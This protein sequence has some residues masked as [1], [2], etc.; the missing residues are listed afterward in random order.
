MAKTS[1]VASLYKSKI[2]NPKSKIELAAISFPP[3]RNRKTLK[4]FPARPE[5]IMAIFE[6]LLMT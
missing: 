3:P 1:P 6:P 4:Y 5:N 2:Q